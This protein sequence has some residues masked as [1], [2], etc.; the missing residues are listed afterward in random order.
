ME[1][2]AS[3][4]AL[5][6]ADPA[7]VVLDVRTPDEF[8]AGHIE[9]AINIDIYAQDFDAQVGALDRQS[10]YAVY[11]RSGVRSVTAMNRMTEL[12]FNS[13]YHLTDGIL[14]WISSDQPVVH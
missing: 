3:Q 11:C 4:F 2:S 9:R 14:G 6:I 8:S 1:Q 7:V 5:A 10:T 13:F 12:G